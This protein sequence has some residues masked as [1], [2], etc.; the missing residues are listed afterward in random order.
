M[1]AKP[2]WAAFW[3]LMQNLADWL[4]CLLYSEDFFPGFMMQ[5]NATKSI[6]TPG[7]EEN[8]YLVRL[9]RTW[10]VLSKHCGDNDAVLNM[11]NNSKSRISAVLATCHTHKR[12]MRCSHTNTQSCSNILF[13]G[14]LRPN[15]PQTAVTEQGSK[16]IWIRKTHT[17]EEKAVRRFLTCERIR[18]MN[19]Q[20]ED[21]IL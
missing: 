3:Q 7:C 18:K 12:I 8:F 19:D 14:L 4:W 15:T 9:V 6:S 17:E 13:P 11:L 21:D 16:E 5:R 2:Y 20:A 10:A 1:W